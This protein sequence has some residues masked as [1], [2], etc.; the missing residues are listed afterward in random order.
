MITG[1]E[2]IVGLIDRVVVDIELGRGFGYTFADLDIAGFAFAVTWDEH[3]GLLRWHGTEGR[4]LLAYLLRHNQIV[5][6][7]L[8]SY[9]N[10]VLAGYLTA[11]EHAVV[12]ELEDK[13]VDLLHL[14]RLKLGRRASLNE[15]ALATLGERK[16]PP[17]VGDDPDPED[18][19]QYCEWDVELTRDLDD[20]RRA[21]GV[22][23]VGGG[24]PVV[25]GG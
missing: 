19:W 6:F 13:T 21:Y 4:E 17:P 11:S 7:N 5:G 23:Y 8:L 1:M 16:L 14:I 10:R 18:V 25:V 9:D 20:F 24:V 3:G 12:G 2:N 15:V 22:L